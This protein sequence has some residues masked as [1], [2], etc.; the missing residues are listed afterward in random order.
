MTESNQ[1]LRLQFGKTSYLLPSASGYNIEQRESLT[2][3]KSP[4]G[5]VAA[6]RTVR[7]TRLPAYCLDATLRVSRRQHWHRAV[8][9]EAV[10][11]AVGL[12]V[13]EIE[14]MPREQTTISPFT[15]LG[16]PPT[17]IG[18]LFSGG[19]VSGNSVILVFDPKAFIA[20]LQ[21]LGEQ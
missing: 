15:P 20:Y 14:L 21:N 16:L 18:H 11:H 19:W 17:R 3:N 9:L 7:Q 12:V 8:F 1:Y 4:D 6:W 5:N 2:I 13:D 10:P